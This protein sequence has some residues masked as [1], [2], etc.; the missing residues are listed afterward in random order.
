[1]A[2]AISN[3]VS[4]SVTAP[5]TTPAVGSAMLVS[6]AG[7]HRAVKLAGSDANCDYSMFSSYGGGVYNPYFSS[8]GATI[9]AATGGHGHQEFLGGIGF[10][11]TTLGW[12]NIPVPGWVEDVTA[13]QES[14]SDGAPWW[15]FVGTNYPVPGHMYALLNVLSPANGGGTKG[16]IISVGRAA[17]T[18]LAH[19]TR[20]AHKLD[21]ATGVW[22]RASATAVAVG[23]YD[24]ATSIFDPVTGRYYIVPAVIHNTNTLRYL[25]TADFD[26]KVTPAWSGYAQSDPAAYGHAFLYTR[27]TT[28]L[29]M[30]CWGAK[31]QALNL[32]NIAAG[33][34]NLTYTGDPVY[35]AQGPNHWCHHPT[36]DRMYSR[37]SIGA[38]QTLMRLTP[39]AGDLLTGAWVRD[40]VT[41]AGDSI[42]ERHIGADASGKHSYRWLHYIPALDCLGWVTVNGVA[43]LNPPEPV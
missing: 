43:L 1:M 40:T 31:L 22:A 3:F 27:G 15:E 19:S 16:A 8:N 4:L 6:P 23:A 14:D 32:D 33:W 30:F 37:Q 38:G 18:G 25:D 36:H 13:S 12:F 20:A 29:L 24:N 17:V 35:D 42:P 41:L 7:A 26:W 9:I 10:D 34:T 21:C 2:T 39:P 11:W 28:R 5:A